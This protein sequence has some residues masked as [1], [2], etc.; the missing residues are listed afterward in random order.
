M[1]YSYSKRNN[2][3]NALL[4]NIPLLLLLHYTGPSLFLFTMFGLVYENR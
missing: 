4:I 2:N 1:N 3:N